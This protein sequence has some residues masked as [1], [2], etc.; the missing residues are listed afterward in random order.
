MIE[1]VVQLMEE[2]YDYEFHIYVYGELKEFIIN[3]IKLKKLI[4]TFIL[5]VSWG[6]KI[7]SQLLKTHLCLLVFVL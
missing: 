3:Y 2:G 5:W 1:V 4:T 7:F 6:L